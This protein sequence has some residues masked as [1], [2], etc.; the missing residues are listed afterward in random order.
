MLGAAP[1]AISLKRTRLS[2]LFI[3]PC[4]LTQYWRKKLHT[5]SDVVIEVSAGERPHWLIKMHEP[6][7]LGLILSFVSNPPWQLRLSPSSFG[8]GVGTAG[9]VAFTEHWWAAFFA[10]ILSALVCAGSPIGMSGVDHIVPSIQRTG[11]S[12]SL[13]L[14]SQ[15]SN[16]SLWM[17]P[18]ATY[19]CSWWEPFEHTFPVWFVCI[20]Q[21]Y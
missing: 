13:L 4:L 20:P 1:S 9:C 6:I 21:S 18:L 11:F 8:P 12:A 15:V 3:C 2:H 16:G 17:I 19:S 10:P 5:V 14:M 7:Q